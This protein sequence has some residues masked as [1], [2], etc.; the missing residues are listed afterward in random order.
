MV[1]SVNNF[2]A[3]ILLDCGAT[4]VYVSRGFVKKHELKTHAYT[5]RTIK[6]KLGD[7]K[8][9]ESI[10]ELMKIEILLQGVPNYQCV[11]VVFD[12]PEEFDCVLGMTFFVNVH[13]D[14]DWKN[15]CF[16]V[17]VSD[18]ASTADIS[19][20]C[21]KCSLANGSG[22]HDAMDYERTSAISRDSCRAAVPETRLEGEV[23]SVERPAEDVEKLS[24]REKKNARAEAMFILGVVDS[25]G[26]EIKYITRKKL[27]KFLR[28]PAKDQPEHDLVIVL[29]NDTI[30]EIERDLKRNDEPNNFGSE[31]ARRFLN[32]DWETFN[33]NPAYPILVEYKDNVFKPE[34]PDG[35]PMERDIEHRIDV[36]DPNTAMYRQRWHLSPE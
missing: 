13:P 27:R 30:K 11:A 16:K 24:K 31:K 23:E 1:Q 36:K 6:V 25:E 26:V 32:T 21:G 10:L 9:G 2:G 22:L 19:T 15:R 12:I 17:C 8:I 34:L 29:T 18:G 14:I 28:L 7:N 3:K 33:D 5:D 20:P 35:L 4:T